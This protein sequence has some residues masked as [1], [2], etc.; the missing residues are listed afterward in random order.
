[1]IWAPVFATLVGSLPYRLLAYYPFWKRLRIPPLAVVFLIGLSELAVLIAVFDAAQQGKNIRPVECILGVV[2]MMIYFTSIRAEL[3]KLAFSYLLIMNYVMI[4]RGL[5]GFVE[6]RFFYDPMVCF[7]SWYTVVL[8]LLFL[9]L[10]LPFMLLFL[11]RTMER[12]FHTQAP[13]FWRTIWL[14]PAL[15][16]FVVLLYTGKFTPDH[17]ATWHFLVTRISL[18]LC[19]LIVYDVL[20]RSLDTI[21]KQGAL[22]E[23]LRLNEQIT[24]LQKSQYQLLQKHIAQTRTARHDLRQHLNLIQA[25]LQTGDNTALADYITAYGKTLPPDTNEIFCQ[26]YAVDVIVRYYAEQARQKGIAFETHL[27]LPSQLAVAE[28]DLCVLL[29]NLLENAW[30]AC[31]QQKNGPLF[32][33]ICGRIIGEQA[34]SLTVDNSCAQPPKQKDGVFFSS[35]HE[36]RGTGIISVQNIVSQ[37]QGI[38]QFEYQDGVFYASVLLNP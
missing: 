38:A 30:E 37:Y 25:Y 5:A 35:K 1:M 17:V 29:G 10:T 18:L 4:V 13:Q 12:V 24:A 7:S 27:D 6:A 21:R 9:L 33:Q 26:N 15:T 14:V 3:S 22:E 2:C 11:K 34:I 28:P 8:N 32:M 23:Q 16:S 36:Q 20:L 19:I 31:D